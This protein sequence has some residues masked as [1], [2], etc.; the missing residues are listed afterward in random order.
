MG[1]LSNA[2]WVA[3]S[4]VTKIGGQVAGLVVLARLVAPT[5][6]GIMAMATVVT[7][8]AAIFRDLG[9]SAAIIQRPQLADEEKTA[10]FWL[11]ITLGIAVG[12]IIALASPLIS[13]AFHEP[14][15]INVLLALCFA[16]PLASAGAAQQA[17]ME[18]ESRF[19]AVA[20][21]EIT[22]TIV[23]LLVA[24]GLAVS[25]AGVYSLVAQ[26]IVTAMLSTTQLWA[27]SRWRPGR[28]NSVSKEALKPIV[29]FGSNLA[30]FNTINYF[31]RNA[32]GMIIGHYMSAAILGAYSLA[33]RIMLFPLQSM[34]FVASRSLYPILSRRQ[35]DTESIRNTYLRLISVVATLVAPMMAGMVV[36]RQDFVSAFIGEQWGL[37]A[38]LLAW[39]APTGFVQAIVSTTGLIF[40]STGNVRCLL[41]ISIFNS[42]TQVAAFA[43][44]AQFGI[45]QLAALYLIAN[46]INFWPNM[47]ITM[48]ILGGGIT[49]VLKRIAA[50][51]VCALLMA[52]IVAT[53]RD[54]Q[55]II[56][57]PLLARL[58]A[59]VAA[60]TVIYAIALR[61]ISPNSFKMVT[62][63]AR[64]DPK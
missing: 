46:L 45:K 54:L 61:S 52:A 32:D 30:G 57:L 36:V 44:G 2:R 59:Q 20:R 29:S 41:K 7:N 25:G 48:R 51:I 15:L 62:S 27:G 10:A 42:L 60:G 18:R 19:Q 58:G 24:I 8:F 40:M 13:L 17:L 35:G 33:Y 5:E 38:E 47:A 1:A 3:L 21:I 6:Y 4:Q 37:T 55:A 9:T 12:C 49:C 39:L 34:T 56:D 50:P 14:K 28:L 26:T 63:L 53:M 22:S 64:R 16:F 31:S 43:I 11:N 23:G